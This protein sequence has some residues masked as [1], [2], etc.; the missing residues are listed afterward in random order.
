MGS[1]NC[2]D[3]KLEESELIKEEEYDN[4]KISTSAWEKNKIQNKISLNSEKEDIEI[5]N[6]I[7]K[8]NP[9]QSQNQRSISAFS[10]NNEK[11]GETVVKIEIEESKENEN[12]G[13]LILIMDISESMG[14]YVPQILTK[15]MPKV[16]DEL[17]FPEKKICH[18]L[19]FSD[20]T[21]YH[22]LTK[23]EFK[24]IGIKAKGY[25]QMLGVVP[26]LKEIIAKINK[27]EYISILCLSD[28]KVHDRNETTENL[29]DLLEELSQENRNINSHVIRFM[30]R[31]GAD[32]DTRLL[33]SLLKF[34]LGLHSE[35]NHLPITFEPENEIM[36]DEKI[37]EFS[38]IIS[39]LFNIKKSGWKIISDSQNMRI[40]PFG[41]K[42]KE[43]ELPE[44]KSILFIDQALEKLNNINI[45]TDSGESKSIET[46]AKVNQKN[47]H[48]IYKET[49]KKIIGD[50]IK[51]KVEGTEK[52]I[53]KNDDLIQYME[54]LE[55]NTEGEKD[56]NEKKISS[57][58]KE[59][60]KDNELTILKDEN[61]VAEFM[62]KKEQE[63][64]KQLQKLVE[65]S[66]EIN[67]N[68]KESELFLILDNS[69]K[70]D[71]H[72]NNLLENV[73][74]KSMLKVG[75]NDEDKIKI[76]GFSSDD[77]EESV[78]KIEKL[79]KQKNI[80]IGS[81]E[82]EF[83]DCLNKIAEIII[84]NPT[85]KYILLFVFTGEIVDKK[86]VRI[87][88]YK[89]LGLSS[90]IR[91]RARIIKYII[92]DSDFPKNENG[93]IDNSKEDIITYGLIK[94]LNT[95][96]INSLRPLVLDEND[97]DYDK[98]IEDVI[99]LLN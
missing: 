80:L 82:R 90:K 65:K 7:E 36:T 22:G 14:E 72:M 79:K 58:L 62:E 89:M 59:I 52:A 64:E 97:N 19:T 30:S 1:M 15:V 46:G 18:L 45:S 68:E 48:D 12:I 9:N 70:T 44:G 31:E 88:A 3:V 96:G 91:I 13:E 24:S 56:E 27:K 61:K 4:S 54:I 84:K 10:H 51:N 38:N 95:D 20:T 23:K 75:F 43:L 76:L 67:I 98:Q 34:N 5:L 69:E 94:Q 77:V 6:E 47:M 37:D 8:Q 73:L 21:E 60:Q 29:G 50:V 33:C 40:E 93:N 16:L 32:P 55:N 53:K 87:L 25:T 26:K 57:V 42:Y 99:R 49:F 63:C 71:N 92:S 35:N 81:G 83:Y 78:V 74:Y 28:G 66:I 41:D 39:K 11:I 85:K 2:I 86:N 17:K